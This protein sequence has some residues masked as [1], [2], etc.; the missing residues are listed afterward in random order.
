M[1]TPSTLAPISR[2]HPSFTYSNCTLD[3]FIPGSLNHFG[4]DTL[5][6]FILARRREILLKTEINQFLLE[7]NKKRLARNAELRTL[8]IF[9]VVIKMQGWATGKEINISI[10]TRAEV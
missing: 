8:Y 7:K 2:L 5:F 4:Q 3:L 1:L 6:A 10:G 9:G